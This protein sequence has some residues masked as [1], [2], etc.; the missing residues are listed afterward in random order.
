MKHILEAKIL[1][2]S[3]L[4]NKKNKKNKK[5]VATK[6]LYEDPFFKWRNM[7]KLSLTIVF[8]Y[9]EID[10]FMK[11]R[12]ICPEWKKF[13]SPRETITNYKCNNPRF[14]KIIQATKNNI[15]INLINCKNISD[16]GI[17]HLQLSSKLEQLNLKYCDKLTDKCFEYIGQLPNLQKLKIKKC[18]NINGSQMNYLQNIIKLELHDLNNLTDESLSHLQNLNLLELLIESCFSY[19]NS[20]VHYLSNITTLQKLDISFSLV[21]NKKTCQSARINFMLHKYY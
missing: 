7:N 2:L 21:G 16:N 14:R 18:I 6:N 9:L 1:Y 11:I 19:S 20:G 10:E 4:Q 13:I 12:S 5:M 17:R 15:T 8:D 3:K